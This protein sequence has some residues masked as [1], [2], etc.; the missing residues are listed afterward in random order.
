[1]IS[2]AILGDDGDFYIFT[3]N[4][5]FCGRLATSEEERSAIAE[6]EPNRGKGSLLGLN[7]N[8]ASCTGCLFSFLYFSVSCC[9]PSIT[10]FFADNASWSQ[11]FSSLASFSPF[12]LTGSAC[13]ESTSSSCVVS[14]SLSV[15]LCH[16]LVASL[17]LSAS[18]VQAVYHNVYH[19]FFI[20]ISS[21]CSL[22]YNFRAISDQKIH[23]C[24]F[25]YTLTCS[26]SINVLYVAHSCM[27]LINHCMP[28]M[29]TLHLC[30][31]S[32]ITINFLLPL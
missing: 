30:I 6:K 2:I 8:V 7:F 19:A 12:M 14:A 25:R 9:T 32:Y 11:L 20:T 13:V 4:D 27:H 15:K 22:W 18:S 23:T 10:C 24:I 28:Y 26:M 1:M 29:C 17:Y 21:K 5:G 31:H 3:Y 16:V